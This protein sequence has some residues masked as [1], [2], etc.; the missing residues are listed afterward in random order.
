MSESILNILRAA[1]PTF[2]VGVLGIWAQFKSSDKDEEAKKA[3]TF[4]LPVILAYSILV[5]LLTGSL[6]EPLQAVQVL[7]KAQFSFLALIVSNLATFSL[8]ALTYWLSRRGVLNLRKSEDRQESLKESVGAAYSTIVFED[9]LSGNLS[10]WHTV[11]GN[12]TIS[13]IRGRDP[14]RHSLMLDVDPN[15]RRNTFVIAEGVLVKDG[16]IKCDVWLER[17]AIF[18]LV[19]RSDNGVRSY[20]MARVDSRSSGGR[21][22]NGV[23]VAANQTSW[24]YIGGGRGANVLNDRWCSVE[25]VFTDKNIILRVDGEEL[26]VISE[27][28]IRSGRVGMFNE[29]QRVFV[30]NFKVLT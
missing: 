3:L 26:P 11:C 24:D 6:K 16:K 5:L 20:Y 13:G 4:G 28:I 19:F 18:N 23:L 9:S 7:L 12:P 30:N 17:G 27:S 25:V 14:H 1:I 10:K 2:L 8:L 22:G 15:S 29:G 21:V